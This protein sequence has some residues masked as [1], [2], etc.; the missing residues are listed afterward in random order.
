MAINQFLKAAIHPCSR[1]QYAPHAATQ[2]LVTMSLSLLLSVSLFGFSGCQMVPGLSQQLDPRA[3]VKVLTVDSTVVSQLQ[4]DNEMALYAKRLKVGDNPEL[5]K[6]PV[7]QETLK[8]LTLQKL[9][10]DAVID[11]EAKKQGIS[12][13]NQEIQALRQKHEAA[14]GGEKALKALLEKNQFSESAF[15][16][17]LKGEVLN[18]KLVIKLAQDA[19]HPVS[20]ETTEAEAKTFY[21]KNPDVFKLPPSIHVH[22][23]LVKAIDA[24]MRKSLRAAHPNWTEAQL[25]KALVSEKAKLKQKAAN[26]F[27]QVQAKPAQLEALAK[28]QSD[29]LLSAKQN[30]DV[31][32]LVQ[33]TTEP[34][35]WLA[36][37]QT[38]VNTLYPRV[39]ETSFGYHILRVDEK[40]PA[41]V[42]PF[43][44]AKQDIM[45]RLTQEKKQQVLA[46]WL[47]EKQGTLKVTIEPAYQPKKLEPQNAQEEAKGAASQAPKAQ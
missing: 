36:A 29:D 28:T 20:L 13:S 22:H 11:Q 30:G 43:E 44:K 31:G 19:A 33:Q 32:F 17:A 8:Q 27:A 34:A 42:V 45:N 12:V 9:I 15:I 40:K 3:K 39:L 4:Y 18:D 23:I 46:Y 7:I 16:D 41:S 26:L 25:N 5:M 10:M 21:A 2:A 24:E 35:F 6:N 47:K 37:S 38:P 14:A 1:Q